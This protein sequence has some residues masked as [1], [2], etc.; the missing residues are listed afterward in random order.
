MTIPPPACVFARAVYTGCGHCP[1]ARTSDNCTGA[2]ACEASAEQLGCC[3]ALLQRLRELAP[4]LP[5][6]H[7]G[8]LHLRCAGLSCLR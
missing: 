4:E 6:T 7:A 5:A 1:H 8:E 2:Q 3:Q